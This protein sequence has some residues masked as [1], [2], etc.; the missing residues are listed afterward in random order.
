MSES[1]DLRTFVREILLRYD[2]GIAAMREE[3]RHYFAAIRAHQAAD[4]ERLDNI[5]AESK[6]QRAALFRM[7]DKLDG[8]GGEAPG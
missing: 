2:R 8:R 7:L 6:A 4:R 3:N 1:D 5:L